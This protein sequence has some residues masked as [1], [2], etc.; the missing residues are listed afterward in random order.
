MFGGGK[1]WRIAS[2]KVVD[3]KK[4]WQMPTAAL[5]RRLLLL[6]IMYSLHVAT[7][8]VRDCMCNHE[9]RRHRMDVS[10]AMPHIIPK[11][12]NSATLFPIW[13]F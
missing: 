1:V 5:R 4:L 7:V 11:G 12:V 10:Y 9:A 3:E 6:I 2:S 8:H 13:Y